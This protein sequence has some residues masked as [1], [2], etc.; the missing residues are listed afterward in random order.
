MGRLFP[1]RGLL[2][3][4]CLS[5]KPRGTM[6]GSRQPSTHSL[7]LPG[8]FGDLAAVTVSWGGADPKGVGEARGSAKT[9]GGW[10]AD[11]PCAG[12]C[13]G[14]RESCLWAEALR[15]LGHFQR[16]LLHTWSVARPLR[17]TTHAPW[18]CLG[19]WHL[20]VCLQGCWPPWLDIA[21]PLPCPGIRA[22]ACVLGCPGWRMGQRQGITPIHLALAAPEPG[23]T[24]YVA[25]QGS[26][27]SPLQ[28]PFGSSSAPPQQQP[29][30]LMAPCHGQRRAAALRRVGTG[31]HILPPR[32]SC[33][34]GA[35]CKAGNKLAGHHLP[36]V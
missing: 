14:V 34:A 31:Q 22:A 35:H 15:A 7:H 16:N 8:C 28:P 1:L 27:L 25:G 6:S 29:P 26:G 10:R 2:L 20:T 12:T 5:W 18:I 17:A 19:P 30:N 21:K 4:W 33:W 23:A 32:F 24:G 36:V 9:L 3:L 13:W 11:A